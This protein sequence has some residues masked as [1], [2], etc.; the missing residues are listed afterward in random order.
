MENIPGYFIPNFS[1]YLFIPVFFPFPVFLLPFCLQFHIFLFKAADIVKL[2][3][4][5]AATWV[6]WPIYRPLD[7][8]FELFHL[9]QVKME[10]TLHI[11]RQNFSS[12]R[13]VVTLPYHQYDAHHFEI[14]LLLM[15]LGYNEQNLFISTSSRL[16]WC[17]RPSI[18]NN[19]IQRILIPHSW[20][21]WPSHS[22][23][24][25][26]IHGQMVLNYKPVMTNSLVHPSG[27][28]VPYDKLISGNRVRIQMRMSSRDLHGEIIPCGRIQA[29]VHVW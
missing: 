4:R 22:K 13:R 29:T 5:I 18:G 24:M 26:C 17:D 3:K 15:T 7:H 21:C 2:S 8:L 28:Y 19:V 16:D 6:D 23:R 25:I 27:T 1:A 14:P 10:H 11:N 20:S 9:F 12:F